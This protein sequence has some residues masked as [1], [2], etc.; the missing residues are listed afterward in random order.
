MQFHKTNPTGASR[1]HMLSASCDGCILCTFEAINSK[2]DYLDYFRNTVI[3]Q[4]DCFWKLWGE[5]LT[6]R[7]VFRIG[8]WLVEIVAWQDRTDHFRTVH[9]PS[10]FASLKKINLNTVRWP[11]T[12]SCCKLALPEASCSQMLS[13]HF[14]ENPAVSQCLQ[15]GINSNMPI[16]ANP[17]NCCHVPPLLPTHTHFPCSFN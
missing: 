9:L 12:I 3:R 5:K 14:F 4:W 16:S 17:L 6:E 10:K 15:P 2:T 13:K 1:G 7:W 11:P 8:G